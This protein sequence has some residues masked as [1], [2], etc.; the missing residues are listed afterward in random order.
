MATAFGSVRYA[1]KYFFDRTEV[2]KATGAAKR[3]ILARIGSFVRRRA[4]SLLRYRKSSS[5]PGQPP[6]VHR[7]SYGGSIGSRAGQS[8]SPLKRFLFFAYDP[9]TD[10]VV[11]GPATTNQVFFDS[12]LKPVTG[13]VPHVLEHGGTVTVLEW[14][15]PYD[16]KWY[17]ADLR[18]K[19]RLGE[20]PLRHRTY[21][22]AARPFMKP[23]V[24]AEIPGFAKHF[25]NQITR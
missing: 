20:R 15:S 3:K 10:S 7:S 12:A 4:L 5:E 13:T 21:S 17:R 16:H 18:S 1:Q 24:V 22:V 6:S 11:V 14:L 8:Y 2:I 19:R 23:A 25:R 9:A